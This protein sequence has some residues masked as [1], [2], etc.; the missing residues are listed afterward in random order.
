[1]LTCFMC[2][3]LKSPEL[4]IHLLFLVPGLIPLVVLLLLLPQ[5]LP[6][7]LPSTC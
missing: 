7:C 6:P 5:S 2:D 3:A 4:L 1:M